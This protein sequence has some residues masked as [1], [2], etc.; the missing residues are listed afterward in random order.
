MDALLLATKLRVPPLPQRAVLRMRLIDALEHAIPHVPLVR[1]A[2]PAGYGKTTLLAQW[3]HASRLRVAWL[4]LGAEDNDLDRF[5]RYLLA[6]WAEREPGVLESPAGLRLG[7]MLPDTEAVLSALLNLAGERQ[8]QLVFVLDDYHV[9]VDA[10]IHR[11]LTFLLDH[12]PPNLH[13]VLAGRAEPPLPLARYRARQHLLDLGVGDLQFLP[14]QTAE[15]V[16]QHMGLDLPPD[17]IAELQTRL[18]G[19][20]AGVQLVS[21]TLR[22]H[23][24]TGDT[25]AVSG[26]HRYIADYLS[27]EVLSGLPDARQRFLLQTSILEGLCASVCDAVTATTGGQAELERLERDNLFLVPLD[28]TRTWFRYHRLFAEYLQADLRRRYPAEVAPL[29]AGLR[30]GIWRTTCRIRRL[31][32]PSPARMPRPRCR[33]LTLTLLQNSIPASWRSKRGLIW[34]PKRGGCRIRVRHRPGGPAGV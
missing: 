30:A 2:A 33:S 18:E 32:T 12:V 13:F 19:W 24:G 22:S 31:V 23:R 26:T 34:F 6:A 25:L 29:I 11:A 10:A 17:Q 9:I 28:D 15:F 21:L 7:A 5:L 1:L 16:H 27:Q 3:A 4:A 20:I 14:D 8:D